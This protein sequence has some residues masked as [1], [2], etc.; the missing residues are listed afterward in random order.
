V[1]QEGKRKE[2]GL[3]ECVCGQLQR[4]QCRQIFAYE[5]ARAKEN[6][7]KS[8]SKAAHPCMV[9]QSQL[10]QAIEALW[11]LSNGPQKCSR[12]IGTPFLLGLEAQF[13]CQYPILWS[14]RPPARCGGFA[15]DS[16]SGG[17]GSKL[18]S[19]KGCVRVCERVYLNIDETNPPPRD[20]TALF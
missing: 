1:R 12:P 19:L 6:R 3:D 2:K 17:G 9:Q 11:T 5:E 16:H 20:S 10:G 8:E 7:R 13:R 15:A 4:R 18:P 14:H